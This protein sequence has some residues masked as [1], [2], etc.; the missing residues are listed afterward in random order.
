MK[1]ALLSD[2]QSCGYI[3]TLLHLDGLQPN[4][5]Q[6]SAASTSPAPRESETIAQTFSYP[7]KHDQF[8]MATDRTDRFAVA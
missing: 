7:K 5:H 1:F 6:A 2:I 3:R 8:M 4:T